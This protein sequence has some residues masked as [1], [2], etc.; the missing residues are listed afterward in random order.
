MCI[1]PKSGQKSDTNPESVENIVGNVED[2][3]AQVDKKG[4]QNREMLRQIRPMNRFLRNLSHFCR[5]FQPVP[6]VYTTKK[7]RQNRTCNTVA[8]LLDNTPAPDKER[9]QLLWVAHMNGLKAQAEVVDILPRAKQQPAGLIACY[10]YERLLNCKMIFQLLYW[11]YQ[12]F[13]GRM[14]Q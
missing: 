2:L 5:T 8:G 9:T 4:K 3:E 6:G 1:S 10:G 7:P 12:S 11:A 13:F 14:P